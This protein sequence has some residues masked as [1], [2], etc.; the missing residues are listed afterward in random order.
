MAFVFYDTETT[1]VDTN[2]DQILQFGAIKTDGDMNELDRFEVRCRLM[3]HVVPS[4]KALQ[5]TRITPSMLIDPAIPTYFEA[6]Q[7]IHKKMS[8]WSPAT[9]FGYNSINFDENLMRQAFYQTLHPIYLTNT[10]GNFRG[11]VLNMMHAA[12]IFAPNVIAVPLNDAGNP[13]FKLDILAPANGFSHKSAHEAI[14][15]V[16][17]TIYMFKLMKDRALDVWHNMLNNTSK[18]NVTHFINENNSFAGANI[19][20]GKK[21][22]WSLAHCGTNP[23]YNAEFAMFDLSYLPEDYIDLTVDDLINLINQRDSPIRIMKSNSQPILLNTELAPSITIFNNL[24]QGE[25]ERRIMEIRKTPDFKKRIGLALAGRY[26]DFESSKYVEKKIFEGFFSK[27]DINIMAKFQRGDWEERLVLARQLQDL[28]ARE[29]ARRLIYFERPELITKSVRGE[30]DN[31]MS[32]RLLTQD[33]DV[34]WR[35]IP[36]AIKEA[37]ELLKNASKDE[38]VFI[39]SVKEF[40]AGLG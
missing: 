39:N 21:Q 19:Y 29:M 31:W 3:P 12:H 13:T 20:F 24:P 22:S 35:T 37:N 15:D 33:P 30:L 38:T 11:D 9:F 14:S 5:V 18:Q 25:I 7:L 27:N 8:E 6:I 23:N 16:E 34:P 10:G 28:R 32:D 2:F 40:I 4:P 17:A 1:G 36:K 26:S